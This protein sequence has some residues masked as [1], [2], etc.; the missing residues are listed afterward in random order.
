MGRGAEPRRAACS[1]HPREQGPQRLGPRRSP[2]GSPGSATQHWP[3]I[4]SSAQGGTA[5]FTDPAEAT[6][7]LSNIAPEE[8]VANLKSGVGEVQRRM[9]DKKVAAVGFCMGGGL[10]WRLLAVGRTRLAAAVPLLRPAPDGPDFSGSK[11]APCLPFTARLDTR[12]NTTELAAQGGSREGRPGT[13]TR[14]RARRRSRLLQR[15]ERR[16]LQPAA[17]ADAWQKVQD[18]FTSY[19]V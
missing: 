10:V 18:W 3:S 8:F 1:G 14:H 6:A 2:A 9:P 15:H 17:A 4:C 5:T 12:V 7:A 11:D 16:A 13:P 19:V